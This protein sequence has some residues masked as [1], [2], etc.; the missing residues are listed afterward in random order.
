ME[1]SV[2][3]LT[4]PSLAENLALDEALL[5]EA[6]AGQ[7]GEVLRFWEWPTYSVVLG[8]SGRLHEDV[9]VEACHRDRVPIYRRASGGGTVLLGRGCLLYSLV[10]SMDRD[11]ALKDI[12]G[13]Y[14]YILNRLA[15]ALR[16]MA[17]VVLEGISDLAV[18]GN[19]I[20]GSAQQRKQKF[21]LHH[22]TLLYDFDL[23]AM[24]RYLRTP[25]KQPG[26]REGRTHDSFVANLR[27]DRAEIIALLQSTWGGDENHDQ[28]P[29]DSIARLMDE[30]YGRDD[31][32]RRR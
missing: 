12:H 3:D 22:G 20:S 29:L 4:L 6:E 30:K 10:L 14:H 2:F 7:R 15:H 32:I 5:L 21:L 31:W 19:K 27:A 26:Y 1:P 24:S 9:D 8:V 18:D 13:S 11:A 28:L 25:V 17:A 23:S 16:P